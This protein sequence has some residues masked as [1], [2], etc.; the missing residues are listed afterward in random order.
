M[1]SI[2]EWRQFLIGARTEAPHAQVWQSAAMDEMP[3]LSVAEWRDDVFFTDGGLRSLAARVRPGQLALAVGLIAVGP[4]AFAGFKWT[5]AS[6]DQARL[7]PELETARDEAQ[8]WLALSRRAGRDAEEALAASAFLGSFG[9]VTALDEF[10]AA[11]A[12][13]SASVRQIKLDGGSL[14]LTLDTPPQ[15]DLVAFVS[16][17]ESA[18]AWKNVRMESEGR[19]IIGELVETA[20]ATGESRER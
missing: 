12:A 1:P 3:R 6:L 20:P 5:A 14:R 16:K 10:G 19:V 17:L 13:E 4:M 8:A 15:Q 9:L 2:E 18:S 11:M 7:G